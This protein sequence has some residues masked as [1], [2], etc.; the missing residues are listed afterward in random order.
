[1]TNVAINGLGRIG[2][3]T[4]K[5]IMDTPELNLV[6]VNDL[7]D[8][9][10]LVYLLKYDTVYGRYD[11]SIEAEAIEL[12]VGGH[13]VTRAARTRTRWPTV[14]IAER[15][16][17]VRMYG[18]ANERVK[19]SMQHIRAGA[20][21]VILS[22]PS[23]SDD[24]DTIVHGVNA[25]GAGTAIVSCA[26]CTTNCITPVMEILDSANWCEE[27]RADHDSRLHR[28]PGDCR[29]RQ[30]ANP[31]WAGLAQRTS[32][33]RPPA[34]R[35]RPQRRCPN[36]AGDS[37]AWPF[38]FRSRS[39]RSPTLLRSPAGPLRSTR[40]TVCSRRKR[41]ANATEMCSASLRSHR[42]FDIIKDA[43]ASVVDLGMT[44]VV[45]GDL[46]KVISWYD[47]EW[48]YSNQMVREAIRIAGSGS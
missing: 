6:A 28:Q 4:L 1:M 43:R 5:I 7:A 16:H 40:S 32:S 19:T 14:E 31:G 27:S 10:A 23:R 20:R 24:V 15:G 9:D 38:V 22:A 26:S 29:C 42:L 3:A 12:V 45:D 2:R 35:R 18:C 47:N 30:G 34:Q 21:Y 17:R 41:R 36:I 48:G 37:T 46:L 44:Q 11:R 33:Q 25:A 13:R 39:G 8:S